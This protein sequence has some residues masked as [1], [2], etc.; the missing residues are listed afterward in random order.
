MINQMDYDVAANKMILHTSE[1]GYYDL[2]QIQNHPA[3]R[4]VSMVGK[5]VQHRVNTMCCISPDKI[6][7]GLIKD[8]SVFILDTKGQ[9]QEL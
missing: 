9:V 2:L 5:R 7:I 3:M 6:L 1:R 4:R 8:E